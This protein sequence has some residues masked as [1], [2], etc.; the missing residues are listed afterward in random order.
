VPSIDVSRYDGKWYEIARLP[1]SFQEKCAGEVAAT[2]SQLDG[3]KLKVTNECRLRNGKWVKAEG[4]ARLANKTGP[5]SKLKVRFAPA[6]L[7]W[8]PQVWG[9][10]WIIEVAPD[11]S[12][13]VVGTPDRKYLWILSRSPQM[14]DADF[15]SIVSRASANR[16]DTSRLLMTRQAPYAYV[17][18]NYYE[19]HAVSHTRGFKVDRH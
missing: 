3:G 18:G 5:N 6:W 1:N 10:Y 7:G 19:E 12:Y 2:Y 17:S 14:E 13:S 15:R 9:D 8:I 16:Y 4:T 11:Y